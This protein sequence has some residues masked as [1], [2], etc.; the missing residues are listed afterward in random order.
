MKQLSVLSSLFII[1]MLASCNDT[2]STIAATSAAN[3]KLPAEPVAAGLETLQQKQA[4][5]KTLYREVTDLINPQSCSSNQDCA[6]VAIG[7]KPCGGP[8]EYRVYSKKGSDE[9]ALLAKADLHRALIKTIQSEQKLV[10][11]CMVTPKPLTHCA[12]NRCQIDHNA[13]ASDI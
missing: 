3:E 7:H 8:D 11:I 6:L 5:A 9:G 2:Q 1:M 13:S 12:A 10:G 4:Y